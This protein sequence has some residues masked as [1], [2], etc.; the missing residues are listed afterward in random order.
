MEVLLY[1]NIQVLFTT[2]L[3]GDMLAFGVLNGHGAATA[4]TVIG[5]IL[6]TAATHVVSKIIIRYRKNARLC[7]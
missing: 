7:K 3:A 1:Q 5:S 6:C 4:L 2:F